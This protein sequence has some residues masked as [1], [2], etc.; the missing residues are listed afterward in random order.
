LGKQL[1]LDNN[2]VWKNEKREYE[3]DES[4]TWR[5]VK[6]KY[7]LDNDLVWKKGFT[8]KVFPILWNKMESASGGVVASEIGE[9]SLESS[10]GTATYPACKF[11]N[12]GYFGNSAYH[13]IPNAN[14]FLQ[15]DTWTVEF[16]TKYSNYAVVAGQPVGVNLPH[17]FQLGVRDSGSGVSPLLQIQQYSAAAHAT[18][19]LLFVF[20]PNNGSAFQCRMEGGTPDIAINDIV[21]WALTYNRLASDNQRMKLYYYNQTSGQNAIYSENASTNTPAPNATDSLSGRSIGWGRIIGNSGYE[22]RVVVDNIKVYDVVKT[23]FSDRNTEGV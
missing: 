16:W 7:T 21:F 9:N 19:R 5:F 15:G 2:N 8:G 14:N 12:G 10:A 20:N 1:V 6:E 11:G 17:L 13:Y 18:R 22:A 23:D 4:G 3:I